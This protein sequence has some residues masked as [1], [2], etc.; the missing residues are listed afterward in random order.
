MSSISTMTTLG[1]PS[2]ALTSKRGG[3][4][5]LRASISVT[6]SAGSS[7]RARSDS[8]ASACAASK[9]T[10]QQLTAMPGS[11][12]L[13]SGL[14]PVQYVESTTQLQERHPGLSR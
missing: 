10:A 5:A 7:G 2:G 12:L 1:A 8:V 11:D 13:I 14:R 9:P 4:L 3:A 6:G